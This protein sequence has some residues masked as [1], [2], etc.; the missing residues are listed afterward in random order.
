MK[1]LIIG[2][3][4]QLGKEFI[5]ELEKY[6][7]EYRALEHK[8]LDISDLDNVLSIFDSI[9]PNVVINTSA[10]NQVD[11]AEKEYIMAYKTNSFGTHNLLYAAKKYKSFLVHY[12]SDYVFDGKK[13]NGLYTE[14]D[15]T[16]PLSE[17]G[18]SKYMGEIFLRDDLDKVLLLR[19]SW[20]YGEGKQNFIYK[21]MQ[22]T[23]SNEFLKVTSDEVSIPTSAKTIV[24]VTLKALDKQLSGLFHLTNTGY[25]SRYELAKF[26]VN[27]L[28]LKNILYPVSIESFNLPAQ[29]PAFSAMENL[30]I[31]GLLNIK[32][33]NWQEEVVVYLKSL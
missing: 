15:I 28:K 23:K 27:T 32:L 6:N 8:D 30:K 25:C 3:N 12:S 11:L 1:Y 26:I 16:N 20:V 7:K 29:R 14:T 4:G 13:D 19:T 17:Y 31:S 10:Y 24:S 18:K 9:K 22:W 21:F 5:K 33:P 2:K